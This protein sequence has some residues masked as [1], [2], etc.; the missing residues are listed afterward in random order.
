MK[1]IAPPR[2]EDRRRIYI[3][4][5]AG[6][7]N[8]AVV[9]EPELMRQLERRGFE[10]VDPSTLSATGQI[11]IFSSASVIVCGHGAA[12]ANLVFAP[13]GAAVVELFPAG[14]V[15]PDYWRLASS[16]GVTYRYLSAWPP[17]GRKSHR[18]RAIVSDIDVNLTALGTM[19][20]Q[21]GADAGD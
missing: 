18:G 20:D 14:D 11:E 2:S 1:G 13:P 21:L 16:A 17:A 3:T 19:L 12:L 6:A 8:R 10:I 9:N 5:T 7:H 4:R 15:L